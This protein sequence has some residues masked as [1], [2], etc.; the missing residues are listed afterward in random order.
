MRRDPADEAYV[1]SCIGRAR[2]DAQGEFDAFEQQGRSLPAD[3]A[4][5]E[6]R[7]SLTAGGKRVTSC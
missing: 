1:S 7:R 3:A 6:V 2:A 5:D 4:L